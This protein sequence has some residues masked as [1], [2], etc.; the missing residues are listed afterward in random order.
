MKSILFILMITL[1]KV[2][3][4]AGLFQHIWYRTYQPVVNGA[5][6]YHSIAWKVSESTPLLNADAPATSAAALDYKI[7]LTNEDN[8]NFGTVNV[9][10]TGVPEDKRYKNFLFTFSG[11]HPAGRP[12][13]LYDIEYGTC[14][15]TDQEI[16]GKIRFF[17]CKDNA[18]DF[19]VSLGSGS[20]NVLFHDG[21]AFSDEADETKVK[22]PAEDFISTTK[23]KESIKTRIPCIT[24]P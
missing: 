20:S 7:Q 13:V 18:K 9:K 4:S 19:A 11:K 6:D 5:V 16:V 10:T 12:Y 2:V 21:A 1:S 14:S 23:L 24:Q 8:G 15:V 22:S 17:T 3:L